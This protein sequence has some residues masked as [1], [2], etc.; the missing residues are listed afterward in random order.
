MGVPV[1]PGGVASDKFNLGQVLGTCTLL[2]GRARR[3]RA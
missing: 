1:R 2:L 3:Q